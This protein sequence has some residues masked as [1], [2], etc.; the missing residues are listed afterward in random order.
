MSV[1]KW[2]VQP[3]KA[4]PVAADVTL[5][6]D[7]ADG[8]SKQATIGS[9]VSA[10]ESKVSPS[11]G[12]VDNGLVS[13]NEQVIN[14]IE[15]SGG[16]VTATTAGPHGWSSGEFVT[17]SDGSQYDGTFEITSVTTDTFTYSDG[18][19]GQV[20][21]A[22]ATSKSRIDIAAGEGQ[23]A[24]QSIPGAFTVTP[25]SWTASINVLLSSIADTTKAIIYIMKDINGDTQPI[26]TDTT[27]LTS[28]QIRA[29]IELAVI[30]TKQGLTGDAGQMISSIQNQRIS[31]VNHRTQQEDYHVRKYEIVN[32]VVVSENSPASNYN[33]DRNSGRIVGRGLNFFNDMNSPNVLST[34]AAVAFQFLKVKVSGFIDGET[35]GSFPNSSQYDNNGTL[36]NIT[37]GDYSVQRIWYEPETD[38][39]MIQYG[40]AQYTAAEIINR[41]YVNENP[42]NPNGFSDTMI[43]IASII[44]KQ[45]ESTWDGD[46]NQGIFSGDITGGTEASAGGGGGVSDTPWSEDHDANNFDLSN[47]K[48]LTNKS[49]IPQHIETPLTSNLSPPASINLDFSDA[50]TT[51]ESFDLSVATTFTTSNLQSGRKKL[52]KLFASG[53]NIPL[54]FPAWIFMTHL[55]GGSAPTQLDANKTAFFQI[56]AVST[57]DAQNI[58]EYIVE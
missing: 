5:I 36:T 23:V 50:K 8:E 49:I 6:I 58:A 35:L 20:L 1:E 38:Q 11:T 22:T 4:D 46:V 55:G 45:G 30:K 31:L 53:V 18:A 25:V 3:T 52:V 2:S 56:W 32:G 9:I 13:L 10:T 19:T 54:T 29:E 14:E 43:V 24:D 17:I 12:S 42:T 51:F 44:L 37:S 16:T 33:M 40:T 48:T 39:M 7:S 27:S 15:G 34:P 21:D 57:N 47:V 26:S 41:S 28:E